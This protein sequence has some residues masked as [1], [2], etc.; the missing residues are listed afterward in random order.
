M[1]YNVCFDF[2]AVCCLVVLLFTYKISKRLPEL[3]NK[4]FATLVMI[5][6]ASTISDI[7][8]AE[9]LN[10]KTAPQILWIANIIYYFMC[11]LM[12]TFYALYSVAL[13]GQQEK[14]KT[15]RFKLI[16]FLPLTI[17]L[18]LVAITPWTHLVFNITSDLVYI[19]GYGVD[20]LYVFMA[21]YIFLGSFYILRYGSLLGLYRR[22]LTLSFIVGTLTSVFIQF[23]LSDLLVQQFGVAISLQM[24]FFALQN[25]DMV[26]DGSTGVLNVKS[27]AIMTDRAYR[28]NESFSIISVNL[29]DL[30]FLISTFGINNTDYVLK[31]IVGF[32]Q[33][34][35]PQSRIYRTRTDT[36]CL[37]FFDVT[38]SEVI[39][40]S[41]QIKHRFEV[42]WKKDNLIIK[43]HISQCIIH[44]PRDAEN[45]E[46]IFDIIGAAFFDMRYR[47][48]PLLMA[49]EIDVS[50]RKRFSYVED[51]VKSAIT[52]NRIEVY[53]QPLFSTEEQRIVG[54]EALVRMHDREGGF[55]SPEEFVPIAEQNGLILR[56]GEYVFEEVCRFMALN[57][58]HKLGVDMIDI[59]L[60]VAQCMQSKLAED[61][62]NILHDYNI[63]SSLINLEITETVAAH[64]PELLHQNMEKL[65]NVGFACSLDD[66]GSGYAN[67]NYILKLPF[68]IIKID[69]EIVWSTFKDIHAHVV[70]TGII[71][72]MH[73]LNMKVVAEGVETEEMKEA[74]TNLKV[75]YLQ[76]YYFS[77]PVPGEKFLD[78]M[79]NQAETMGVPNFRDEIETIFPEEL[80]PVVEDL[81]DL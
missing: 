2:A 41:E 81:E 42:A 60:S 75:N 18:I 36:F 38:D 30:D 80:Y 47:G 68:S 65:T 6:L 34:E 1:H 67:L 49:S 70:L 21:Y 5:C 7:V 57:H 9:L 25:T 55:V 44:C 8:A 51:L 31:Q 64:T 66:Y 62:V 37:T 61:L 48:K 33:T 10:Y 26:T 69:K 16:F 73:K 77:R 22:I 4:L 23:F 32:F 78:I 45:S 11:I 54:A 15:L 14:L 72:M 35:F 58:I 59:N 50:T 17:A 53:Y 43:A 20:V 76:G 79:K 52:E 63:S 29:E 13:V 56:I 28:R 12:P 27:F 3:K 39:S 74:L 40:F 19:R 71:D 24:M 46:D